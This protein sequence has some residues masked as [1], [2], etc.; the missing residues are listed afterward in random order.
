MFRGWGRLWDLVVH[1]SVEEG[2]SETAKD[3]VYFNTTDGGG[4][5]SLCLKILQIEIRT[6]SRRILSPLRKVRCSGLFPLS[7]WR[8]KVALSFEGE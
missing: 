2:V 6:N 3:E 4:R 8:L 1:L 5:G 7:S